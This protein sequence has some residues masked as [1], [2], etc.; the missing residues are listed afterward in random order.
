MT[1]KIMLL[2]ESLIQHRMT[3]QPKTLSMMRT[4]RN[5]ASRHLHVQRHASIGRAKITVWSIIDY[6]SLRHRLSSFVCFIGSPNLVVCTRTHHADLAIL[7]P[8][9]NACPQNELLLSLSLL[10]WTNVSSCSSVRSG[11]CF[12]LTWQELAWRETPREDGAHARG[13]AGQRRLCCRDPNCAA[14]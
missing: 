12:S 1:S 11:C 2:Q 7:S 3:R 5:V 9:F 10:L 4:L 13:L 8:S 14:S 6:W